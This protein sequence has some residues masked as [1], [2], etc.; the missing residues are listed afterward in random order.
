MKIVIFVGPTV[1][2]AEARELCTAVFLPPVGQGDLISALRQYNPDRI[3]IIDGVFLQDLAVWHKEILE[4]MDA[5]CEVWGASSMGALRAAELHTFGM[6]GVGR[7]FE[8]YLS[9]RVADDDEVAMAHGP[10]ELGYFKISEPMINLRLTARVAVERGMMNEAEATG[11]LS[12]CKAMYFPER[13][14]PAI[15]HRLCLERYEAEALE[16]ICEA[17]RE[18]YVDQKHE[19]A[20]RLLSEIGSR[21]PRKRE[22]LKVVHS[23][24]WN[25][26]MH[27]D[28][29]VEHEGAAVSLASM[30]REA[31]VAEPTMEDRYLAEVDGEL[32]NL[33]GEM[34]G[35]EVSGEEIAL[36]ARIFA[37]RIGLGDRGKLTQ[38]LT[39][40]DVTE[41][42]L[43]QM[44]Q[45][46]A[47][48]T[49]TRNWWLKNVG[50]RAAKSRLQL[51]A[52]RKNGRYG[53]N[54][55]RVVH[56]SLDAQRASELE[57]G[58]E[59]GLITL[60]DLY[61]AHSARVGFRVRG[62]L[63][64]WIE[65]AGFAGRDDF[66]YALIERLAVAGAGHPAS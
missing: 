53:A 19:D 63:I 50:G 56:A 11:F 55:E 41:E 23:E 21:A 54:R 39:E 61:R 45:E 52:L 35:I 58:Y 20:F 22:K 46:M 66:A 18:C 42:Q 25:L 5:G 43:Q 31:V 64:D 14:V 16:R 36:E 59:Q 65:G 49:K 9:G 8:E 29:W 48:R 51:N 28:R 44:H 12:V 3:G 38:W 1:A 40:N 13:T 60:S 15:L 33:L 7:V 4:S 62:R 57:A 10:A 32:V 6:I 34:I 30:A 37:D 2:L 27:C 17:M 26:L 24:A 47:M